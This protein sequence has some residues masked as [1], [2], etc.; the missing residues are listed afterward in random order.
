M[1]SFGWLLAWKTDVFLV[2][3][4]LQPKCNFSD[5]EKWW[6]EIR[7]HSQACWLSGEDFLSIER[8]RRRRVK[9]KIPVILKVSFFCPISCTW[10]THKRPVKSNNAKSAY[11][12]YWG[13]YW[14]ILLLQKWQ[15]IHVTTF[16]K[17][18]CFSWSN[19]LIIMYHQLYIMYKWKDY[20]HV[21]MM[22]SCRVHTWMH[23]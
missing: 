4:S 15:K 20:F 7:L 14:L 19:S 13:L 17:L 6:L 11:R 18:L 23:V 3:A 21:H 8:G 5:G 12:C 16:K 10:S 9:L 22:Y 1:F 2:F